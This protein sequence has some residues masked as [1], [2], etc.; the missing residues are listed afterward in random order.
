MFSPKTKLYRRVFFSICFMFLL[1]KLMSQCNP[2]DQ[3]PTVQCVNAPF[4]CLNDACYS[5]SSDSDFGQSGWCGNNTAVHNPQYFEIITIADN[6]EIQIHVDACQNGST[7]LQSALVTSCTWAPCPGNSVP[8]PDILDCDAGT[9]VGGTMTLTASGL[10]IGQHLWLLID[11]SSGSQC[12]YTI[13]FASGILEPQID[14]DI[15]EGEAT[16]GIVCQGFDDLELSV[17]PNIPFAHGYLWNFEWNNQNVTTTLPSLTMDVPNNAPPGLWDICVLAISGCD[18]SD[19]PF[20]FPLEIIEIDDVE[21][22]PITL[23]PEDFNFNWHGIN[24]SGPG[25]YTKTFDNPDGCPYDSIWVVDDYPEPDLGELDTLYCLNISFD[26]FFYEGETYFSSGIYPLSY[27]DMGLNGCDS[28]AELHL[29]LAGIDAF[30][31]LTCLNGEFVLTPIIQELAPANANIEWEWLFEGAT[32]WTEKVY[33]VLDGGCY[34]LYATVET[35]VGECTF[36]VGGTQ[37]CFNAD[38]YWPVAPNLGFADTTVCAQE[39]IIFTVIEDPFGEDLVYEWSAPFNVPVF[40][41]GSNEAEMDFSNSSGGQVCV[42]AVGACGQGPST[43]FEVNLQPSPVAEFSYETDICNGVATV[44][45]FTG[46]ASANTEVVW[47]FDNPNS[48]T[49]SGLGPYTVDWNI[50]GDKIVSLLL[51]QPGC[52]TSFTSAIITVSSLQPP[53]LNCTS[54]INSI[55]FDWDD[56]TGASGYTVSING[57]PATGTP[58]STHTISGLNPGASVELILTVLSGGPCSNLMDTLT[59]IAQNCPPPSIILFGIDS[60]CLN[61]PSVITLS[62]EVNGTPGVGVWSGPGITDPAIG[63][64]DPQISGSGQHQVLFTTDV[65]GCLFSEPY[66]ITVFDSITADFTVDPL[67]CITD[68]AVVNYTGNGSA[69]ATYAFD[70]GAATVVSGTGAGPYEL[71]YNSPGSKTIRL[72]ISDNGCTSDLITQNLEVGA[73]LNLPV[74]NCQPNTSGVKFCWTND[75]LVSNYV[76]NTLTTHS[77]VPSGTCID[78][79]GLSPGDSVAIEI[80]SQTTGPCPERTD[81]FSCIARACPMPQITVSPVVDICLYPGTLPVDLEVVVIGGNGTGDWSGTGVTDVVNGIFDPVLAGAGAH[82]ITFHYLDD[83]CDFLESITINVADPPVAFVSNTSFILTCAGGNLL[84]LDGSGSSGGNLSYEWT[85]DDGV[86]IMGELTPIAEVAAPGTYQLKV[87]H[88]LSGCVDSTSVT[89]TQDANTPTP[90]PGPD[91]VLTCDTT[92]VVLGGA[93]SSG[94][95]ITYLWSTLDGHIVGPVNGLQITADSVGAYSI[96][97]RDTSNG[98]QAIGVVNV[99]IDTAISSLTLTPGDT[100]DCNTSQSEVLSTLGGQISDYTFTWTTTDGTIFGSTS[101]P[102]IDVTQGGTYTLTIE[103]KNNGCEK[104]VSAVVPESDEIIDA[105]DVSQTNITCFGD[106]N[107][108]LVINGVVGG[109][110][111]YT[112]KWSV[113]PQGGTSL[114]PLA[115]GQYSLTVTDQN[116]CTYSEVFNLSE[117]IKIEVD[118]GPNQIVAIDDSVTINLITNINPGAINDIE[119]GGLDGQTCPGCPKLEFVATSSS[120]FT[121]VVTDTAGCTALDSMRLTVIVP[122]IIYVPT[123]FSPN[124]DGFNDYFTISGKRNLLHINYLR[125]YD[126]WGNMLFDKSD[127]TPGVKEEGWDGTHDGKRIMPGVYV[128]SAELVYEDI[129]ETIN[130]PITIVK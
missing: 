68:L 12:Q 20:C 90:V 37:F 8:C 41:D 14:E 83:G 87:I 73:A 40:Q 76:V 9:G 96:I 129:T 71:Q 102:N 114:S 79:G 120:T 32:V 47:N 99:T 52:D 65:G 31:E 89:V 104:T 4:T 112:Y 24:I 118:L 78:F 101:T 38:L 58:S 49:G 51:I 116:G 124:G 66:L 97:V 126:R 130:G 115:P 122:R 67:I 22:D 60:A 2:P 80:I 13:T 121:A 117:P 39:G 44:I 18:T 111:P 5:T 1:G 128:Y 45:T 92:S 53:V 63:L 62:A 84:L 91:R 21:K 77:G 10:M 103:N 54:T 70:F 30:I 82:I 29:T 69:G 46:S 108:A 75:P 26:P 42:F 93:S 19:I 72:Q 48:V 100:I 35:P 55:T 43:C 34:E 36:L 98:C 94:T 56:V 28:M 95:H 107:G 33:S 64:F 15:T 11:G 105:V 127:L 61:A 16:P 3:L 85:T 119:W 23:C 125:I 123:A 50:D 74:V 106:D 88:N 25:T 7:A 86:F 57:Q 110:G 59:C 109:I 81:T 113:G 17:G 27:P 6:I